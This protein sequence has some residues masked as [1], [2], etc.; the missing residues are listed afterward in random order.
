MVVLG[1]QFIHN[2]PLVSQRYQKSTLKLKHFFLKNI[3]NVILQLF[4]SIQFQ[5]FFDGKWHYKVKTETSLSGHISHRFV[6]DRQC[7][8]SW[9]KQERLEQIPRLWYG[10]RPK[11]DLKKLI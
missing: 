2:C 3:S 8:I 11:D 4:C 7:K 10:I 1:H 5:T 6:Y 9:D